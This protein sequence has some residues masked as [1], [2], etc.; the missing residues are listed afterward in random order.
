MEE[1]PRPEAST[2]APHPKFQAS[3]IEPALRQNE[4]VSGVQAL[5]RDPN[6]NKVRLQIHPYAIVVS[7][8]CDLEQDYEAR[9][10]DATRPT[11]HWVPTVLLLEATEVGAVRA[12]INQDV[13]KRIAKHQLERFQL[14]QACPK[15]HDARGLG[16]PEL[17][18]D[19]KRFFCVGRD[20]LY[21]QLAVQ[22]EQA[23]ARRYCLRSPYRDHLQ[24]KFAFYLGRVG[25]PEPHESQ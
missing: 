14:I 9:R 15:E 17:I 8:D 18:V 20:D 21:A 1:Q 16:V 23:A 6:T 19:F 13:I 10:D 7:Q 5:S 22:G 3:G 25:L 11:H 12:R 24:N 4:V 2:T